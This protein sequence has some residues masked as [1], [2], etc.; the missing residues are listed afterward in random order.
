M[1][2]ILLA[3]GLCATVVPVFGQQS[4]PLPEDTIAVLLVIDHSGSM[5]NTDRGSRT[6]RWEKMRAEAI[7]IVRKLPLESHLWIAVFSD[8]RVTPLEPPFRSEADRAKLIGQLENYAPPAG[9]THLFDTLHMAFEEA[10]R[11]SQK[12]PNRHVA[13]YVY[14]DGKDEGSTRFRSLNDVEAVI[15]GLKKLN[16]NCW[17]VWTGIGSNAAMKP[18]G[19]DSARD[20]IPLPIQVDPAALVLK[21]PRVNP[22]RGGSPSSESCGPLHR[23]AGSV[24]SCHRPAFRR[25]TRHHR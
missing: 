20:G 18:N 9:G 10:Q 2:S 19:F 17:L 24:V 7:E 25:R 22:V 16:R 8:A 6:T 4:D 3:L 15:P 14:T 21:N 1:R 12:T 5:G 11:L 13:V 23:E